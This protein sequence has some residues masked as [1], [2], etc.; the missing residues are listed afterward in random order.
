[1][2]LNSFSLQKKFS[3]KCR[4]LYISRSISSGVVR[5]GCWA[6]TTLA[7]R[8]FRSAMISLLS[9]AVSPINASKASPSMSGGTPTVSNRCPGRSTKR[10]RLPSAS[11]SAR[12][13]VVRPP[14]ERPMAWRSPPLCPLSVPVDLNNGRVDHGVFYVR[15]VRAGVEQPLPDLRLHPIAE[16]GEDAVPVSK[17]GRQI[18]P[19]T[20]FPR[21]PQ[22]GFDKQAVVRAA[23]SGVARLAETQRFHLRPLGVRQHKA[24]HPWREA[25]P[26]TDEKRESQQTLDRDAMGRTVGR[27]HHRRWKQR[28]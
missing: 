16:A 2:R 25:Q 27:C 4:H 18:A 5:R 3:I 10:T 22:H 12:I 14:L 21:N 17:Q 19:G 1:M 8:S 26:S 24:V 28:D 15:L 20:P 11:V 7:P 23:A 13:L 6:M 9:K